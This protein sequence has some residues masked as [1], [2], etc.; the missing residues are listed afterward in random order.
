M[1]NVNKPPR[2]RA[3]AKT[4]SGKSRSP[5]PRVPIAER[6]APGAPLLLDDEPDPGVPP[7]VRPGAVADPPPPAPEPT[8]NL[9]GERATPHDFRR[10]MVTSMNEDL[11]IAPHVVEAVVN[12][13]SGA[14]KAGAAG[15][16]NKAQYLPQRRLALDAWAARLREIISGKVAPPPTLSPFGKLQNERPRR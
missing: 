9:P 1:A 14:A 12:H 7:D 10:T 11:M 15:V 16:Y 5:S 6:V 4:K 2:K 8:M 3:K 13:V